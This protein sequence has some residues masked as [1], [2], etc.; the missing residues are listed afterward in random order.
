MTTA[1]LHLSGIFALGALLLGA[2]TAAR[3]DVVVATAGGFTVRSAAVVP[4]SAAQAWKRFVAVGSWWNKDHTFSGNSGNLYLTTTPG[5]CL[6]ERLPGGGF[7]EHLRVVYVDKRR[8]LRLA[9]ALGPLQAMGVSGAY[10]VEFKARDAQTEVLGTYVVNG[11]DAQG[12][13]KI[14]P[15]VDQMLSG[16]LQGFAAKLTNR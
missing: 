9:G 4:V 15:A 8:M 1:R 2:A 7:V 12:L 14:A 3:A 5:G 13:D 6:C 10:T 11:F 16:Q